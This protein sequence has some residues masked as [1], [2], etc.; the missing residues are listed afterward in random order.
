[1]HQRYEAGEARKAY[2]AALADFKANP[3]SVVKGSSASF[4]AGKASYDYATLDTV[5]GAVIPSLSA[6]GLSH[7][8]STS[9][10]GGRVSVT[11]TLTHRDGHAESVTL[12]APEDTSGSKNPIQAIGSTVTYLQRY[13]L[14]AITGLAAE[15]HDDDGHAAYRQ[16]RQPVPQPTADRVIRGPADMETPIDPAS[17]CPAHGNPWA[18]NQHGEFHKNRDGT[19]C[20][21]WKGYQGELQKVVR[22]RDYPPNV[23]REMVELRW[24]G[25]DMM[26]M[27]AAQLA[28][29]LEMLRA[30][31]G[32]D[33][34]SPS[35]TIP[36]DGK[37]VGDPDTGEVIAPPPAPAGSI[38]DVFQE[39][40]VQR[41][42]QGAVPQT[43]DEL[44][45]AL[46]NDEP[47]EG[48]DDTDANG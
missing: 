47:E 18:T 1:M 41:A 26:K 13:T 33:A 40:M 9:Q 43:A 32:A 16:T 24:P 20:N 36:V 14:L 5:T 8:W 25:E 22:E 27:S 37:L 4:G 29:V 6:H 38:D 35:E 15:G 31:P 17:F 12:S 10:E 11:C 28:E 7:H 46:A 23:W 2:T 34:P 39:A 45:A 44:R 30:Y 19:F 42:A 48:N 3:P 21:P